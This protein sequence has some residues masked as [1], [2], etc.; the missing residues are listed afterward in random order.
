MSPPPPRRRR[1]SSARTLAAVALALLAHGLA[2][3]ALLLFSRPRP[4]RPPA[5]KPVALR[6]ISTDEWDRNRRV[7]AT[8]TADRVEPEKRRQPPEKLD[9]QIVA[10]APGNEEA[11]PEDTQFLAE[12]NNR[13]EKQTAS[14]DR[15]PDYKNPAAKRTTNRQPEEVGKAEREQAATEP[16][17]GVPNPNS[18]TAEGGKARMEVPKVERRT[19]IA[20]KTPPT[21]LQGPGPSVQNRQA[22]APIDGNAEAL[23]VSPGGGDERG[24][25]AGGVGQKRQLRLLPSPAAMDEIIGA[26]ANDHLE[27]VEEGEGT[28]LN[29]R[30]FRYAGYFNRLR[31]A[32]GENWNPSEKLRVRDPTGT[33][34]S[35]RDRHT[36]LSITLD[37]QGNLR[38][39]HVQKSSGLDFLDLEAIQSFERAQPFPN[40]PPGLLDDDATVRFTFGFLLEM[41]S[42]PRLRL[43]RG[44]Y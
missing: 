39:V 38:D 6:S 17:L 20:L 28:F 31:Q 2:V 34:Y 13:V 36:V 25:A 18:K 10:V 21:D 42:G 5:P 15:T 7:S 14:R 41:G 44:G 40:P 12:K 27:D 33:I 8:S 22:S 9:G 16:R 4:E 32:V 23:K 24:M 43:Y 26:P 35:G 30:E 29:T 19:Q 11:P 3:G 37:A 1:S